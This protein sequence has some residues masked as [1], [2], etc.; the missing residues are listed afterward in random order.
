MK[1]L[2]RIALLGS[3]RTEI[4]DQ[5]RE[6]IKA[7]GVEDKD[8]AR[9][10]LRAATKWQ[11][12]QKAG[13]IPPQFEGEWPLAPDIG[14]EKYCSPAATR[15]LQQIMNGQYERALPEFFQ[16]ATAAG[17]FLPPEQL[18]TLLQQAAENSGQ[19]ALLQPLLGKHA[20]WLANQHAE[21]RLLFIPLDAD[22]WEEVGFQQRVHIFRQLR[23]QDI[24]KS[25]SL[26]E[27]CWESLDFRQKKAFL[28]AMEDTV[29]LHDE[30]LLEKVLD[31]RRK[32]V[33]KAATELLQALD[34]SQLLE[35]VWRA[36][37]GLMAIEQGKDGKEKP[38]IGLPEEVTPEMLR[39]GIDPSQQWL[40]GGL[41]ASR[42][43]QMIA[44]IP[45]AR[46]TATLGKTPAELIEIF[47]KSDYAII[48]LQAFS[49][50]AALHTDD[51]WATA[52]LE[53]WLYHQHQDR[54][55]DFSPKLLC[56]K[57]S[58]EAFNRTAVSALENCEEL[59][60]EQDL[61]T[62]LVRKNT[63][64]WNDTLTQAFMTKCKAWITSFNS[65]YWTAVHLK[66]ILQHAAYHI[67]PN[68]ADSLTK[69]W[70][71]SS[72]AWASWEMDIELFFRV[73]R[74]RWGMREALKVD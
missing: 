13:Y 74:F 21:W 25:I 4:P 60:K 54:W 20:R 66:S 3:D 26:L 14:T 33:R 73:L 6:Q 43:G 15:Y 36:L 11:M 41:R 22:D 56:E 61:F 71:T 31:D 30:A 7:L 1:D 42:L 5:L 38:I 63:H 17:R 64:P 29:C 8:T 51:D 67:N 37:D 48:L 32:E 50:A 65:S 68:L 59:P 45:P 58:A 2:I 27:S 34:G 53:F 72:A 69:S 55:A 62:L 40:R 57:L 16:L 47:A 70:P 24:P 35:R 10:I 9:A 12:Q 49:H 18:P 23:S 44:V 52:I 46:W 28:S 19:A 39:D